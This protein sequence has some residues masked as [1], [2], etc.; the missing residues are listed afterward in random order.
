MTVNATDALLEIVTD[1]VDKANAIAV[2]AKNALGNS[3]KQIKE[4]REDAE[5]SDETVKKY[6]TDTAKIYAKLEELTVKVNDHIKGIL[7]TATWSDEVTEAKRKE[8]K[9]YKSAATEA[10]KAV[11]NMNK[12]LSLPEPEM[13]ELLTFS[14]STAKGGTGTDR[15]S[16]GESKSVAVR[17]DTGGR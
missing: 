13:P 1:N 14:G 7:G 2:E 17:V 15:N 8:Y 9:E 16:Y 11:A 4:Y 6:Q 12:I 3:A 5:T 10:F